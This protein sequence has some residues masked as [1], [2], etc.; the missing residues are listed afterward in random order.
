MPKIDL[1]TGINEIF[2]Y[3]RNKDSKNVRRKF[4][5]DSSGKSG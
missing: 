1:C 3:L 4:K 2:N 5:M